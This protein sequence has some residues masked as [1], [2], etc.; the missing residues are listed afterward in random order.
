MD[1]A[2]GGPDPEE[3]GEH[4]VQAGLHFLAGVLDH[5]PQLV[6]DQAGRQHLG[7]FAALGLAEQAGGQA[8]AEGVQFQFGDQ[9]LEA[10]DQTAIGSC[11]V[12]NAVL[13]ADQAVPPA[14]Q[15]EQ[16]VPVGAVAGQAGDVVGEDDADLP[17]VD[18]SDQLLEAGAALGRATGVAQVGV[19]DADLVGGPTRCRRFVL[20]V[21]L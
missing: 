3:G 12:A 4:Q 9:A 13:V 8:G 14:A 11:R 1:D 5:P 18:Q 21:I 10:Q 7:Q 19:D 17:L 15:V 2:A 16:G 6:T 20:E